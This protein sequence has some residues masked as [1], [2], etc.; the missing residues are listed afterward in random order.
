MPLTISLGLYNSYLAT[1][2]ASELN[3]DHALRTS[4]DNRMLRTDREDVDIRSA[5]RE[6]VTLFEHAQTSV[7]KLMASVGV[8]CSSKRASG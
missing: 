4:F 3:L 8:L 7:F 6:T 1:G 5:L 2:A